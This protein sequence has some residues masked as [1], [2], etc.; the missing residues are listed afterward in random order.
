M[1]T[2]WSDQQGDIL[3]G[4]SYASFPADC[5]ITSC[6]IAASRQPASLPLIAPLVRLVVASPLVTPP[7]LPLIVP[8]PL[9][10]PLLHLLS[11]WLLRHLSSRR[12]LLSAC[13]SASLHTPAS[14]HAPLMIRGMRVSCLLS[15]WLSHCLLSCHRLPSVC[16][17]TS[18]LTTASHCAPLVSLVQLVVMSPLI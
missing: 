7:P 3:S 10:A 15:G 17:S 2:L 5:C 14:Y 1:M 16:A 12:H 13:A 4:P 11:G 18:H 9:I 6:H 8:P